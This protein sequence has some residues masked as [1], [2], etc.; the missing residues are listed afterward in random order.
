MWRCSFERG[1]GGGLSLKWAL[2]VLRDTS[3]A[4][5]INSGGSRRG[6]DSSGGGTLGTYLGVFRGFG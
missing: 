2:R 3:F 4:I 5:T 1:D 6:G